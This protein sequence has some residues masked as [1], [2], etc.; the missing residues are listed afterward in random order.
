[1][2]MIKNSPR[3][4]YGSVQETTM[5]IMERLRSVLL[6]ETN[7]H[8]GDRTQYN[9]LQSSLCATLQSVLRKGNDK[10]F[11]YEIIEIIHLEYFIKI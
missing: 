3:D 6:M 10:Y 8:G 5:I 1:M 4:C 7:A 2:E 9:E 11:S